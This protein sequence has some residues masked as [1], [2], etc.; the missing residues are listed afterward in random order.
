MTGSGVSRG[1][2][3]AVLAAGLAVPMATGP[4]AVA[5][6]PE[7]AITMLGS[8]LTMVDSA[9]VGC[10]QTVQ[11]SVKN[12]DG[13]PVTNGSVDFTSHLVNEAGNVVGTVPVSADGTA[14][15]GWTPDVAGEHIVGALYFGGDPGTQSTATNIQVV[16][17][18]LAGICV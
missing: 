11:V 9:S 4:Q 17:L 18:P 15:I 3:G 1:V 6:Q 13:S 14:S 5:A 12:P 8:G 16:A 7:I 10:N 2:A